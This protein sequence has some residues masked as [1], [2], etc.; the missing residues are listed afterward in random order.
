MG[1]NARDGS[2]QA[3]RRPALPPALALPRVWREQ[4]RG[5]AELL[6]DVRRGPERGE[7]HAIRVGQLVGFPRAASD[8]FLRG[9]AYTP[10]SASSPAPE[11]KSE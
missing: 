4:L 5:V 1:Q 9:E 6:G 10:G 7:L 8:A 3:I 11:K 2:C